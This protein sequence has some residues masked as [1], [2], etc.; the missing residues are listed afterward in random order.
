MPCNS[1]FTCRYAAYSSVAW[2]GYQEC[3]EHTVCS[4]V[5]AFK[6]WFRFVYFHVLNN[7]SFLPSPWYS[8][9]F[10]KNYLSKRETDLTLVIVENFQHKNLNSVWFQICF[11]VII[12]F[13]K[14]NIHFTGLHLSTV[15]ESV[16][17]SHWYVWTL[18]E[19]A[20][21][22]RRKTGASWPPSC[23]CGSCL[24]CFN[25]FGNGLL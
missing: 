12:S 11:F 6:V 13:L 23:Y 19:W 1:P 18:P 8:D 15:Y 21:W 20:H 9:V 22:D 14:T 10:W 16:C 4:M 17:Y 24:F 5:P 25:S 3:L 7:C 2:K